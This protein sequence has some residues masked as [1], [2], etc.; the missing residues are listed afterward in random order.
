MSPERRA[1]SKGSLNK[2]GAE[3]HITP[4]ATDQARLCASHGR[5][6]TPN[7]A[8]RFDVHAVVDARQMPRYGAV[9]RVPTQ[10]KLVGSRDGRAMKGD[11]HQIR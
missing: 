10:H 11:G 7:V 2:Y 1:T 6:R 5:R 4:G 3:T 8:T 9:N